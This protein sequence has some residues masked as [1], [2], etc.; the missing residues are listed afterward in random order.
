MKRF[1]GLLILTTLNNVIYAQEIVA[2]RPDQTESS[3]TVPIKSFQMEFGFGSENYN[4]ETFLLIPSALFRYGLS[5]NVELRFAE[6]VVGF[7]KILT[8]K[9]N[10]AYRI[11]S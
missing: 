5:N 1:I 7:K 6:Q 9:K 3:T 10:M 2:D 8:Q 11:L 4:N